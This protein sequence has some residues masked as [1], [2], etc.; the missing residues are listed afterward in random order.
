[1]LFGLTIDNVGTR[2]AT[3][4]LGVA[5]GVALVVAVGVALVALVGVL[6][7]AL[8]VA[9]GVGVA[10]ASAGRAAALVAATLARAFSRAVLK[11][12]FDPSLIDLRTSAM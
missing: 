12:N 5:V 6:G 10:V 1:M 7:V 8:V 11:L 4:V 2:G 3:G 9:V